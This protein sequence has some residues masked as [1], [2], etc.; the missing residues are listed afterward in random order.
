[1]KYN[2]APWALPIFIVLFT[3]TCIY[4]C[5][6]TVLK[7]STTEDVNVVGYLEKNPD[8]FSLFKEILDRTETSAF[9]NAYGSYT[10]F[11]PTNAG[12][13]NWLSA[14][15]AADVKTADLNTLKELVKFHI[16][17]DTVNTSSFKDGKLPVPTMHGQFLITGVLNNGGSSSY[18]IN[19]QAVVSQSN[20]RVGNGII[21]VINN[22]LIPAK[23]TIAQQ[24]EANPDFSIFVQALKETGYFTLLN[25]VDPDTSKRWKT[26]LAESNKA[27]ADS[28]F[29]TYARLKAKYSNTGNPANPK[30]SLNLYVAYHI[31]DGVK[32][33]GDIITS[34]SH[35]T[36]Q[37]QEV[38]STKLIN[39]E[40][41]VNEDEFN[42]KV[43]R[44]ILL[45]RS[46]SDNSA[47]NGVWHNS[48]AHF[49]AK[50]RRPQAIY[51][52]LATFPEIMKLT[53][54]YKKRD[55]SFMKNTQEDRPIQ[56]I[57]FEARGERYV[58]YI[59]STTNL[60]TNWAYNND[61]LQIP[62]GGGGNVNRAGWVEFTTP[63]IIK[64]KYNVWICYRV[65]GNVT[66][67][68]RV[69]GEL[70]QRPVNMG[71]N[72][73]GGSD[74]ELES[75]GWKRYTTGVN[76]A[77]PGRLVGVVDIKTTQRYKLRFEAI[78]NT[79][80]TLYFDMVHFIP[81]GEPQFLPRFAPDGT[82][83]YQ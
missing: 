67:N 56:D 68:V 71:V 70:M 12:V 26:V 49:A 51:W 79:N 77:Y 21:H 58:N 62:L 72:Y 54:Y 53:T 31:V 82:A 57:D 83:V 39:Q 28:G 34:P 60:L 5:K 33:L 20:V 11:V 69:G 76:V 7:I 30:D 74:A 13:K 4:S 46:T 10:V 75:L 19:R 48:N 32:F 29:T 55:F 63:A 42:G 6:K 1:M 45:L 15:G 9:L 2:F 27:L 81:V 61:I 22:V 52:D 35:L 16:L 65:G 14:V 50:F 24:L 37:P 41:V 36:L 23:L 66:L 78:A 59:Y 40:V 25:T 3:A 17:P 18:T 44:G 8:S 80:R 43:E 64:G 73:P 47:T 38:I